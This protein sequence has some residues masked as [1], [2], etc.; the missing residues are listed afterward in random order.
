MWSYLSS[1]RAPITTCDLRNNAGGLYNGELYAG[2]RGGAAQAP[3]EVLRLRS[4]LLF[5]QKEPVQQGGQLHGL[6]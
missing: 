3:A 5:T 4:V 6:L 1:G 2:Y